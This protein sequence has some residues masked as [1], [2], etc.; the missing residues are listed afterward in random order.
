MPQTHI[1]GF[2]KLRRGQYEAR[3]DRRGGHLR[4]QC[5][6]VFCGGALA[7]AMMGGFVIGIILTLL[8]LPALYV[9]WFKTSEEANLT[10]GTAVA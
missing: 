8:F 5:S 2:P 6:E 4:H 1:A 7:R 9:I 10:E 3:F